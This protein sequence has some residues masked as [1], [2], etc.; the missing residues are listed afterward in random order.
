MP[1]VPKPTNW[2]SRALA[3]RSI[4]SASAVAEMLLRALSRALA[5]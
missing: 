5:V 2:I 1:L 3:M 4:A